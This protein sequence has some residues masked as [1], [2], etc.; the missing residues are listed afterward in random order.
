M[1]TG[2]VCYSSSADCSSCRFPLSYP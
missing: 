2:S 1:N